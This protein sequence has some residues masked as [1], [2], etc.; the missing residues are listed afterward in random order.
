MLTPFAPSITGLSVNAD[1]N[2]RA[3][4]YKVFIETMKNLPLAQTDAA[5]G[6]TALFALYLWRSTCNYMASKQPQRR[7]FWFLISTFRVAIVL[8]IYIM[9]S[10]LCLL[11]YPRTSDAASKIATTHWAILGPM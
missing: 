1:F 8:L 5:L 6:L 10:A 4:T 11:D 2:A 7:K 3:Q 9:I